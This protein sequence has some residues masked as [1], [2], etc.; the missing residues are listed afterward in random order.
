MVAFHA[1]EAGKVAK[2]VSHTKDTTAAGRGLCVRKSKSLEAELWRTSTS[3]VC[4]SVETES[5]FPAGCADRSDGEVGLPN[6]PKKDRSVST[7]QSR[8]YSKTTVRVPDQ[9]YGLNPAANEKFREDLRI[10]ASA[11]E[12]GRK[13]GQT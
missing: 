3:Y 8:W 7:G 1:S 4:S 2:K 5:W 11:A 13:T 12:A 9:R 10:G 6:D